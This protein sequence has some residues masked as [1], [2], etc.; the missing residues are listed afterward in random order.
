M[1]IK[2]LDIIIEPSNPFANCKLERKKYADVLTGIV[3]AYGDGF[4]L[5]INNKWGTGKTTFVKMWEQDLKNKSFQ[6][7]YFNAWENDF[8]NN[9]LTALIGELKTITKKDKEERFKK[10]LKKASILSKH[11]APMIAQAIADKYIDTEGL[12]KVITN[13]TEGMVDIFENDVNEYVEKK[14]GI[15][16][17]RSSLSEFVANTSQGKPLIFIIDELDRCRPDYA[18][19]ILEQVKHFFSV[20]NIIFV[21]SIDK[22]QLGNAV[23]GVYGS[24]QIDAEEYL[25][26]FIDIEYTIPEPDSNIF[27]KY[28]YTYFDFDDF[29]AN[30]NRQNYPELKHDKG[31][32]QT[33]SNLLLVNTQLSLRQQEKIMSHSRLVLRTFAE[34]FYVIPS[35][36]LFLIFIKITNSKLYNDIKSKQITINE[37]QH[38]YLK[39]VQHKNTEV[40]ERGL[41]WL[42][43]YLIIYYNNYLVENTF[44]RNS[45]YENDENG[46][47]KLKVKSLIIKSENNDNFY[48]IFQNIDRTRNAGS[49]SMSYFIK[50]IELTEGIIT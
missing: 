45:L 48:D 5:A 1:S 6:T 4:V 2:H 31:D 16:E 7:V 38:E 46:K 23:R 32:F 21:L 11:L 10:V 37:L 41:I 15:I 34:N 29:F 8:E 47:R 39:I 25:R 43:A 49:L 42:E 24:E 30:K 35:V 12:K 20:P 22:T 18:V 17:F 28:L 26:R 44:S 19:S 14:K 36:Y 3:N 27:S 33:I 50:R 9:P 13:S 40:T